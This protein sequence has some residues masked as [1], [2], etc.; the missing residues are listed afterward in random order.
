MKMGE[1]AIPKFDVEADIQ[2]AMTSKK[3]PRTTAKTM[4]LAVVITVLVLGG[5]AVR[6]W[7][8]LNGGDVRGP[9]PTARA[10]VPATLLFQPSEARSA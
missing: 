8:L 5:P 9:L 6:G 3:P 1:G 10:S 7:M 2:K 4:I